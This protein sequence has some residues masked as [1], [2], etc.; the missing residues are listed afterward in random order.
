MKIALV[1]LHNL[2]V[3]C[4]FDVDES[5]NGYNRMVSTIGLGEW[6]LFFLKLNGVRRDA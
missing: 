4:C 5:L 3:K 1:E 2:K 6:C